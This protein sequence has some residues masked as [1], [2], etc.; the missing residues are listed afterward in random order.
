MTQQVESYGWKSPKEPHSCSYIA[1]QITE[2][3]KQLPLHRLI[4]I[5]CGNGSLCSLLTTLGYEMVGVEY[6]KQGV[7][8][9]RANCPQVPFYNYS[10]YDSPAELLAHEKPFDA[11]ISTEVIEHLFAPHLLPIYAKSVLKTGGYLILTTPYMD[12]LRILQSP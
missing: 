4:D 11:V 1:A 2:I 9:A 7:E 6:D 3:I 8:I 12:I 5:G 10:V